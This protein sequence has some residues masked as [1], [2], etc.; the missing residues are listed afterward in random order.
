MSLLAIPFPAIDPVAF[1]IGPVEV[2]WYGLAYMTGLLFGWYYIKRMLNMP[3]L[4]ATGKAPMAVEKVDDL[5]LWLVFG[6]ILG[7]RLGYV[8]FYDPRFF[9]SD[10]L[11]IFAT[12]N[13][14]MSFHGALVGCG[15]AVWAFSKRNNIDMW[16]VMDL[17]AASV[18]LGL[19]FGRLANFINGELWGRTT[20]VSWGMV[21]PGAGPTPRH[22]SQLYEM[23]FEGFVLFIVLRIMTHKKLALQTPGLVIGIFLTGYALARSFCEIFRE[24]DVGHALTIGPLTAGIIYSIPM[25][26][27]GLYFIHKS[28]ARAVTA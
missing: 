15:L 21:F 20:D 8:L 18:P 7:G 26:L 14:G 6:V 5:L 23:F 24:P 22:P 10:P 12:W 13:G 1:A 19:I 9:W 3:R 25:L 27:L 2:K 4:W 16:S 11:Q 17:C 28:R